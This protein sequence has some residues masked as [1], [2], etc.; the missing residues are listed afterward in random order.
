METKNKIENFR[1][2]LT[3]G[4]KYLGNEERKYSIKN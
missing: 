3:M 2:C 4:N 1:T